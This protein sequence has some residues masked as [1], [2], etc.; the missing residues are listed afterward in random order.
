MTKNENSIVQQAMAHFKAGDYAQA[1][2]CYQQAADRYGAHLFA[3]NVQLC[4]LRLGNA[5]V[6][7]GVNSPEA[8]QLEQTQALLEYYYTRCQELEYQLIDKR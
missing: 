6:A 3:K 2:A 1:K 7:F 4:D 5:Q 8:V